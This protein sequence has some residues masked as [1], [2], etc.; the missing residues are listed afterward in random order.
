MDTHTEIETKVEKKS[1]LELVVTRTVNAPAN[2][3]WKAWT[4][5]DLFRQWWVP[6][7]YG[8][9]LASCELDVRP[10]GRYC[11]AFVH[12]GATMEFFGTYLEVDQPTLLKWTNE[13]GDEG[14]TI[15]T[16]TFTETDGKT[17]IEVSDLYPSAEAMDSGSTGAMPEVLG[18]LD[19]LLA[20]LRSP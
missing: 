7:S 2:L 18:Q 6:K 15:T 14:R 4:D 3:V 19:E 10:G 1:D 5:P 9:T 13:E 12:E 11:L 17:L 20:S 8:L 16:A